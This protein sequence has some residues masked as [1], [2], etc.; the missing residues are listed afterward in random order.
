MRAVVVYE[1]M[2]GNT[3]M[4]ADAIGNG[5]ETAYQV[6]V[7]AVHEANRQVLDGADLLVV[8][9]PTHV[10]GMSR[11]STRETAATQAH[12]AG[13]QVTLDP[14]AEGPGLREWLESLDGQTAKAAAF[15]TRVDA[16]AVFT[17]RAS[18]GIGGKLRQHG[19]DLVAEP[20]S[21]LVSKDN[22]LRR[23]EASRAR[24]WGKQLADKLVA[25]GAAVKRPT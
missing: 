20:E 8:G 18:K 6:A 12:Q 25:D 7:V 10:H 17:G 11:T 24:Q 1:S 3:H 14:E 2:F 19:F 4:V 9:G 21:F 15:D 22:R 13:S 5:L 16:P 23:G